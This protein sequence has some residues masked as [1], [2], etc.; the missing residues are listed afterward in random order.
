MKKSFA[1]RA[2]ALVLGT[3]MLASCWVF[4]APTT[5]VAAG[6]SEYAYRIE[7]TDA[8]PV[9][10]VE[11]D[12]H[13]LDAGNGFNRVFK[14]T[15]TGNPD[16]W[17]WEAENYKDMGGIVIWYKDNNGTA[18]SEKDY[19]I[20]FS[21]NN[22]KI[23]YYHSDGSQVASNT[24]FPNSDSGSRDNWDDKYYTLCLDLSG[25]PTAYAVYNNNDHMK[26][27]W[28]WK[29]DTWT[30]FEITQIRVSGYDSSVDVTSEAYDSYRPIF[31]GNIRSASTDGENCS[32]YYIQQDGTVAIWRPNEY[33]DNFE[34]NT[35]N[36][37]VHFSDFASGQ[38]AMKKGGSFNAAYS[39]SWDMP[40]PQLP[41]Y[42]YTRLSDENNY[43][44]APEHAVLTEPYVFGKDQYGAQ[45]AGTV[46]S[47]FVC[48][49]EKYYDGSTWQNAS[50][51]EP[52]YAFNNQT[53]EITPLKANGYQYH[54]FSIRP[55]TEWVIGGQYI[56]VN[57]ATNGMYY[58]NTK[59]ALMNY[60]PQT[61]TWQ[62]YT[63][64]SAGNTGTLQQP[65]TEV[66]Y[67][68]TPAARTDLP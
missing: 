23:A 21:P 33:G 41:D 54:Q 60:T 20:D 9:Y 36:N 16:G 18:A 22:A 26:F 52:S 19:S 24:M 46:T 13:I 15:Q 30:D 63:D 29:P 37:W 35:D 10:H 51:S 67:G 66:L 11:I 25:F 55:Q 3:V 57:G 48:L 56:N 7:H 50:F 59:A 45:L 14:G 38:D 4:T 58:G 61:I 31:T 2:L 40:S 53:A 5:S 47:S 49:G 44:P 42:N 34:S 65:T 6:A 64:N 1:K 68:D 8:N 39:K 17:T 62:H 32:R 28:G 27:S 12:M 43:Y